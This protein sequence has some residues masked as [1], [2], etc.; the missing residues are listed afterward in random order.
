MRV[1]A[2]NRF[3]DR[4]SD[5]ASSLAWISITHEEQAITVHDIMM[6]VHQ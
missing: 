2:P 6:A 4:V 3:N 5:L 1:S